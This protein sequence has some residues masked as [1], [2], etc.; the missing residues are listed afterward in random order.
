MEDK[1]GSLPQ[2]SVWPRAAIQMKQD[3]TPH[4]TRC[5]PQ[6]YKIL[7]GEKV[8]LS[9]FYFRDFT[10]QPCRKSLVMYPSQVVP[11]TLDDTFSPCFVVLV[12]M[13][14]ATREIE[15]WTWTTFWWTDD[16]YGNPMNDDQP[17]GLDSR[18]AHFAMDTTFGPASN[19]PA[20][21]PRAVF[22]LYLEGPAPNGTKSNCFSGQHRLPL[23]PPIALP[24]WRLAPN[25]K[26]GGRLILRER[27]RRRR[28]GSSQ[29]W[30]LSRENCPLM[31]SFLWS[32]PDNQD[33]DTQRAI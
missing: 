18:F 8:P 22:N 17:P 32:I 13:Q 24:I 11:D 16:A 21:I 25:T 33:P 20:G 31:T 27:H 5:E 29:A 1:N 23:T 3:G 14:I 30:I 6:N 19:D 28:A 12:G 10:D 26:Q 2:V 7:S 15:N 9:C 4:T